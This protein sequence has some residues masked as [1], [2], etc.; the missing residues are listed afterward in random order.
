MTGLRRMALL[1]TVSPLLLGLAPLNWPDSFLSRVE[2]LALLQTLNAELL[3]HPSATLTLERWCGEHH[4]AGETKVVARLIRGAEKTLD[5]DGGR[6]LAI[7]GNEPVRYRHV[8]LY[9]GDKLLSEAD[10]W[11][12]PSRL[13]GEMNRLLD[14]TDTPFGRAVKDLDFR[15]ETLSATLLWSPLPEGWE[16]LP[17]SEEKPGTRLQVPDQ[18]LQH[19]AVLYTRANVPFSLVIE[20][21]TRDVLAFTP[22]PPQ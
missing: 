18:V 7:T 19:R 11:Y 6:R 4:M 10:N 12:V 22:P 14:E 9:C 8:Q 15:R 13:T 20:T 17:Q 2:I 16:M 5:A 21:Y 3:S 1:L